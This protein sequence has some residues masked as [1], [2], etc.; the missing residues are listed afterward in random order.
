MLEI[1]IFMTM[2]N[3]WQNALPEWYIVLS[4]N[5]MFTIAYVI[6]WQ[7]SLTGII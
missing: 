3:V 6:V 4:E 1:F 5:L 7:K 2:K